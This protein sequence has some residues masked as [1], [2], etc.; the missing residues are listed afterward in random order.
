MRKWLPLSSR[1]L[2][3]TP[4]VVRAQQQWEVGQEFVLILKVMDVDDACA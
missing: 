3:T 1:F 4:K 2:L